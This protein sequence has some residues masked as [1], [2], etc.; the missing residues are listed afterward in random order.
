MRSYDFFN[1]KNVIGKLFVKFDD[2]PSCIKSD[3]DGERMVV[4]R[5]FLIFVPFFVSK[6]E[7]KFSM[8]MEGNVSQLILKDKI[9]WSSVCFNSLHTGIDSISLPNNLNEFFRFVRPLTNIEKKEIVSIIDKKS[10]ISKTIN[11]FLKTYTDLYNS[12]GSLI[13]KLKRKFK[14]LCC[15]N[16]IFTLEDSINYDTM[17]GFY[18]DENFRVV[19]DNSFKLYKELE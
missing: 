19:G 8:R 6:G 10:R 11:I 16:S 12:Y 5:N 1:D 13:S 18:I 7:I 4:D 3:S 17:Y 15:K 2:K 9:L 14:K